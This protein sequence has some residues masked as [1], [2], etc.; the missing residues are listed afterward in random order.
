MK[1]LSWEWIA[2]FFQAEGYANANNRGYP[3]VG[4]SQLERNGNIVISMLCDFLRE[5]HYNPRTHISKRDNMLCMNLFRREECLRLATTLLPY[6][7]DITR[8]K[9]SNM[10]ALDDII[11]TQPMTWEFLTGFWEGDGSTAN[12]YQGMTSVFACDFYQKDSLGLLN[13]IKT[14]ANRGGSFMEP[15]HLRITD[16]KKENL[17]IHRKLLEHT[18]MQYR[19]E[20]LAKQILLFE[21]EKILMTDEQ[22]IIRYRELIEGTIEEHVHNIVR[23]KEQMIEAIVS[24]DVTSEIVESMRRLQ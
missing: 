23:R 6:L 21:R 4:L 24:K 15:F 5:H 1:P 14:F 13:T 8:Q 12:W 22:T 2:G 20:Q 18:R 19:R 10:F 7:H 9:V 16:S 17:P 11:E 3:K